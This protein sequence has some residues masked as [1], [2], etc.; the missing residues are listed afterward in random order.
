MTDLDS[1]RSM[2]QPLLDL[3][4]VNRRMWEVTDAIADPHGPN[5]DA[6]EVWHLDAAGRK[7]ERAEDVRS[8][9]Q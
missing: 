6:V 3:L 5:V 7:V 2:S 4:E 9:T 1:N 8:A